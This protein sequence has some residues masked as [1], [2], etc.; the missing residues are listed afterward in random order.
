MLPGRRA[1]L[2]YAETKLLSGARLVPVLG[3]MDKLLIRDRGS[4]RVNIRKTLALRGY[5]VGGLSLGRVPG[6]LLD[7]AHQLR[8]LCS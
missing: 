3:V 7:L 8:L 6:F 1:L 2:H 4:D 5:G